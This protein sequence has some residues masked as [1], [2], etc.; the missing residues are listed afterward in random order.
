MEYA[1]PTY[2]EAN[3][4]VT[5]IVTFPFLFGVMYGDIGHGGCLMF[6]S[7]LLIL[8]N[9][10]LEKQ[11]EMKPLLALRYFFFL[12]GFFAVYC[13]FMYNDFMSLPL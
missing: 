4:G 11:P 1:I 6:F 3:P 5:L 12:M 10:T 8:F 2:Q 7:S 9:G 13:G